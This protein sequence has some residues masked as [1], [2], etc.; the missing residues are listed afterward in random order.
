[1]LNDP[2]VMLYDIV[3][4]SDS[5]ILR[6]VHNRQMWVTGLICTDSKIQFEKIISRLKIDAYWL[7]KWKKVWEV[8]E[9]GWPLEASFQKRQ[10]NGF[11]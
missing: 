10:G 5:I 7:R 1:M 3:C 9:C 8:K 11:W 6:C 4:A 2:V